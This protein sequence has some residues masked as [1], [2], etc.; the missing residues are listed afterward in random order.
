MFRLT[1][2]PS[3][4]SAP[5]IFFVVL[6]VHFRPPIGSPAVSY[7]ISCLISAMIS[8]VFFPRAGDQHPPFGYD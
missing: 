3:L 7:F 5:A 2:I 6:R 8:G 4:P 1:S